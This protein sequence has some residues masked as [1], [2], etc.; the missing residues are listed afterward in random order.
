M[1][2][3]PA[4]HY[5]AAGFS[6][7]PC[8]AT[9]DKSR[10]SKAPHLPGETSPG[11]RDGG[12]WL[13]S[14]DAGI[15]AGWW[16]RWPDALIGLPT[17]RRS[18]AVVIDLDPRA[19]PVAQMAAALGAWCGGGLAWHEPETGE[20][21]HPAVARTQSGGL[22]LYYR[23][24]R[25]PD[26]DIGSTVNVFRDFLKHGECAAELAHIDVRGEGGYVIAPP[27]R[28]D[29]GNAYTWIRRPARAEGGGWL[30]PPLPPR[31][32]AV[33]DRTWQPAAMRRKQ[34]E[35]ERRTARFSPDSADGRL[36][37]YLRA[38]IDGALADERRAGPGARNQAVYAA[39]Q[40]LSQFVAS[41][42][43]T[44]AEAEALLLANLPAGVSASEHKIIGT[45][46]S[47]LNSSRVPPF[48]PSALRR[49]G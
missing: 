49:A 27:S 22:H 23:H 13:A 10:G 43:L 7:F 2:L 24:P 19:V 28:M 45:I 21:L 34:A 30:L 14:T 33:I 40:R 8:R 46:R 44:R 4:Q 3:H 25:G 31:L 39:A 35:R 42:H 15:V 12:H 9:S 18:G 1:R 47:G 16:D 11:A 29:N 41:G 48:D 26:G 5:A 6:V 32:L 37:N 20:V 17:G 38:A 36:S